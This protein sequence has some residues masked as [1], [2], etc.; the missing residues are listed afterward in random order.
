MSDK[1]IIF[2][3]PRESVSNGRRHTKREFMDDADHDAITDNIRAA[4]ER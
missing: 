3:T 2:P 4:F 1:S